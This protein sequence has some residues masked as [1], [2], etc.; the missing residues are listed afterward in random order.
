M[1]AFCVCVCVV[2]DLE[3]PG[4][5]FQLHIKRNIVNSRSLW[6]LEQELRL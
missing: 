5:G 3:V 2:Q 6:S 1:C 4:D